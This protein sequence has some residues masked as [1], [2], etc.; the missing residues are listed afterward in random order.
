MGYEKKGY[1]SL[2]TRD[3]FDSLLVETRY[4][5]SGEADTSFAV[6]GKKFT[7]PVMV[8]ISDSEGVHKAETVETAGAA[9]YM[10]GEACYWYESGAAKAVT[11]RRNR[12]INCSYIPAWG[13]APVTVHPKVKSREGAFYN[14]KLTLS[15]NEFYCFDERVLFVRG[16][17]QI[18][19]EV[20]PDK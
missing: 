7:S 8:A 2:F 6:Y 18:V 17:E 16:T 5:D 4:I 15:E 1:S 13:E 14:G 9:V 10:E 11:L 20:L 12:F 19:L 3:Y